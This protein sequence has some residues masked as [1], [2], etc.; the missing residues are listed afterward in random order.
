MARAKAVS[1]PGWK[2]FGSNSV[3]KD[4]LL[5]VYLVDSPIPTFAPV[6]IATFEERSGISSDV[7]LTFGL[8]KY[9]RRFGS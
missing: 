6:T 8:K 2:R 7:H 9:G 1:N 4:R 5:G 3:K